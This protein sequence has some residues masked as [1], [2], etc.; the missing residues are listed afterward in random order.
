MKFLLVF[1]S[2]IFSLSASLVHASDWRKVASSQNKT[3]FSAPGL[4]SQTPKIRISVNDYRGGFAEWKCW[5]GFR[6]SK[7]NACVSYQSIPGHNFVY[8]KARDVFDLGKSFKKIDYS[9]EGKTFYVKSAFGETNVVFF[10]ATYPNKK[11]C[12]AHSTMFDADSS[13]IMGWYCGE[14]RSKID[15]NL[16]Q[17]AIGSLGIRDEVQPLIPSEVRYDRMPKTGKASKSSDVETR[18]KEAKELFTKGLITETDY[19][20]L[21]KNILGIK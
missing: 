16:I 7:P 6:D 11:H 2:I 4:E 1:L 17:K 9:I 12:F 20:E 8:Y 19:K 15:N 3:I 5:G 18:L 10:N 14:D 21:K 13:F